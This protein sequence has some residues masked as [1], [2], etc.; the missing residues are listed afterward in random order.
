MAHY[1]ERGIRAGPASAASR[2]NTLRI[3]PK[4]KLMA[5]RTCAHLRGTA[6]GAWGASPP[7]G[8]ENREQPAG[9][10]NPNRGF[11]PCAHRLAVRPAPRHSPGDLARARARARKGAKNAGRPYLMRHQHRLARKGR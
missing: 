9:G 4:L 10:I 5:E 8:A 11:T 6:L 2:R 7:G 1:H 3:A